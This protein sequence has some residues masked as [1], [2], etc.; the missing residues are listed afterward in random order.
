M[1]HVKVRSQRGARAADLT[2]W[3]ADRKRWCVHVAQPDTQRPLFS[4]PRLAPGGTGGGQTRERERNP[5]AMVSAAI[6]RDGACGRCP[7]SWED[8]LVTGYSR[9]VTSPLFVF[10]DGYFWQQVFYGAFCCS[11]LAPPSPV[12]IIITLVHRDKWFGVSIVQ[13]GSVDIALY[14]II[15]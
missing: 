7:A 13:W 6:T 11:S 3:E 8:A 9:F 5:M 14:C 4:S 15:T 2:C 12:T 1:H 10:C